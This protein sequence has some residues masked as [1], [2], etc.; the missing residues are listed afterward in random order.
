[1]P[2][3]VNLST[4]MAYALAYAAMGWHVFPLVPKDKRPLGALAPRGM[5][6]AT[7]DPE[8]IS[9][10]WRKVP[11]A[12]IGI[13]LAT[14]GLM[15]IDVDPRNGGDETFA[16]LQAAHGA[17]TSGVMAFTGGGGEH[18]VFAL[19]P[20]GGIALP[21]V[22]GPGVDVKLN[23]YIVVEPSIHPSGKQYQWEASSS[24][25]DGVAPS[26]LPDWLR[27]FRVEL[28]QP[29]PQGKP[30]D[31]KQA[32]DIREAMYLL[33]ADDYDTWVRCGMALQATGWGHAAYAMW[34]AWAQQSDKFDGAISAEKWQ[35]FKAEKAG[36]LTVAWIFAQAQRLGWMNPAARLVAHE[37]A[38]E[39]PEHGYHEPDSEAVI[40]SLP[41]IFAENLTDNDVEMQ[42]IVEDV[43]TAHGLTVMYGE[44]NSGKSFMAC[45]MACALGAG[46]TWMGKRTV[47]GAVLYVAGEGA[48]SIKMRILAWRQHHG[49]STNVAVVPVAVNLLDPNADLLKLERACVEV[50][51]HYGMPVALIVVDTLARAFGGG[52]ENA[53]EDMGAVIAHADTLR[54]KAG[55]HLMFVHHSGKDAA[56]GSRGHSSLH[57]A[58]DTEINVTADDESGT[59]SADIVKQRELG[60]RGMRVTA[61]F[62]VVR[63]GTDQWGKPIT[64][65]VVMPTDTMPKGNKAKADA[66]TDALIEILSKERGQTMARRDLVAKLR[67]QEFSS[68]AIYRTLQK[69]VQQCVLTEAMNRVHLN[70]SGASSHL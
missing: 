68:S 31:A 61:K 34:C 9:G 69:L 63:M 47:Q 51:K 24:P 13:A 56:K 65:C 11:D 22:L 54:T 16:D 2:D 53:S 60:T 59:H 3:P 70:G 23:G 29:E 33:D 64:T 20:S 28:K 7:T 18:H 15:A 30:V 26:P 8:I 25:L 5:L 42:Q 14:S 6:N 62:E 43:L 46:S 55:A 49:L 35:T 50:K 67:D 36:G 57:G 21:G 41:L 44:P 66:L 12:G 58:T 27:S 48:Q 19:P 38:V 17:L 4:P 37:A 52:N 10:W 39:P 45:D 1:M 40:G 32:R